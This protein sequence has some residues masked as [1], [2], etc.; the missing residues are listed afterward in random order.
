MH[1]YSCE[2][3]KPKLVHLLL[4]VLSIGLSYF[5]TTLLG[6]V[7]V[8]TPW[9]V[10]APSTLTVYGA[11]TL[12]FEVFLWRIPVGRNRTLS[13]HPNLSGRWVGTFNSDH[14]DPHGE[15]NVEIC[16]TWSRIG[17]TTHSK[18]SR[19]RSESGAILRSSNSI[20]TYEYLNEPKYD[21]PETMVPHRG[22][23][24]LELDHEGRLAGNYYTSRS[25]RTT[26][27][28]E[29]TRRPDNSERS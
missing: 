7:N 29:L 21:S 11:L 18:H 5:A 9:W 3:G 28:I 22:S 26:G 15:L 13:G 10:T 1:R 14:V 17:V 12:L 24:L 16:Q 8:T 20:L 4:A 19:S 27:T 25:R 6:R 23:C 2:Y